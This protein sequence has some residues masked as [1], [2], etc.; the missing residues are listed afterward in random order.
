MPSRRTEESIC[1][2]RHAR[3]SHP[4]RGAGPAKRPVYG[5]TGTGRDG[6]RGVGSS[7]QAKLRAESYAARCPKPE[8]RAGPGQLGAEGHLWHFSGNAWEPRWGT[9][10]PCRVWRVW[11][12]K[13]GAGR[14]RAGSPRRIRM[15][16]GV[17]RKHRVFG[18][19]LSELLNRKAGEDQRGRVTAPGPAA[20]TAACSAPCPF[21][22]SLVRKNRLGF[23]FLG[24]GF[25][26]ICTHWHF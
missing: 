18:T 4:P 24:R 23:V 20:P 8:V 21:P 13:E 7:D 5:H 17:E 22:R 12:W 15:V 10:M 6:A 16:S 2:R 14:R 25:V 1:T 19:R 11:L 3:F 26:F 9:G